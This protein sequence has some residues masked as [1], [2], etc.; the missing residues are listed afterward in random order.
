MELYLCK[1]GI[2]ALRMFAQAMPIAINNIQ[3]S[4]QRMFQVYQ[5]LE[6]ELG[7]HNKSFYEMLRG[8]LMATKSCEEAINALPPKMNDTADR[9]E[10]YLSGGGNNGSVKTLRR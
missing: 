4:T 10:E 2:E 7:V 1:E 9:I 5:S 6:D 8:V 3:E